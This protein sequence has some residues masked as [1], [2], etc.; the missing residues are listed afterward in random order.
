MKISH[1]RISKG[2]GGIILLAFVVFIAI[3]F[4]G[5]PSSSAWWLKCP[6]HVLTG[7]QCPFCGM[8]RQLHALLHLRIAEAWRLNPVLLLSYP[9][10]LLLLLASVCPS[11]LITQRLS[12][13]L[14][15]LLAVGVSDR[16]LFVFFAVLL[17]WGVVRN[18]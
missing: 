6:L 12:P 11:I 3:Y 8:Q 5:N 2:K 10:L 18:C 7:W 17:L 14:R 4:L 1:F 9:Y 15:R 13:R 16:V